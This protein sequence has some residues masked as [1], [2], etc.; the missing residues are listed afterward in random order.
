MT[1][2]GG[3]QAGGV[4]TYVLEQMGAR[5]GRGKWHCGRRFSRECSDDASRKGRA[6]LSRCP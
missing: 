6:R 3:P 2:A 1:V 5:N 4:R